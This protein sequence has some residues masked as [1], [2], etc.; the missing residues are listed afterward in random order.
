MLSRTRSINPIWTDRADRKM[1]SSPSICSGRSCLGYCIRAISIPISIKVVLKDLVFLNVPKF[2]ENKSVKFLPVVVSEV[3][4]PLLVIMPINFCS[5]HRIVP[6]SKFM[7]M[8]VRCRRGRCIGCCATSQIT[9]S[10]SF[11]LRLMMAAYS[12]VFREFF[13]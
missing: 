4:W 6:M 9:T 1:M 8:V 11:I 2:L 12:K 7:R 5:L 3:Y 10:A 13:T